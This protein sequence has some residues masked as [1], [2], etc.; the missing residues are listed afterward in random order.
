MQA[1]REACCWWA[2]TESQ[3]DLDEADND[4]VDALMGMTGMVYAH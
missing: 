1:L 2:K 4:A 3:S